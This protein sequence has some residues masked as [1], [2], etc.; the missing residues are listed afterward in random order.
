MIFDV[1]RCHRP[2]F[3]QLSL[4]CRAYFYF[5]RLCSVYVF[6]DR[7]EPL[8]NIGHIPREKKRELPSCL[9]NSRLSNLRWRPREENQEAD[10]LTN[11]VFTNFSMDDRVSLSL[12]D[13]DLGLVNV[14][15]QTKVQFDLM[16][17]ETKQEAAEN[18]QKRKRKHEKTAW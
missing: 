11:E 7:T 8:S 16:R 5:H 3:V 15:W 17:E 9:A 4:F 6:L 14:L 2:I 10:E 1:N 18:P 12:E 13:L